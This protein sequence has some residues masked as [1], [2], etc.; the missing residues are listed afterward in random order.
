V[1]LWFIV[2]GHAAAYTTGTTAV[3]EHA[4]VASAGPGTAVGRLAFGDE[5]GLPRAWYAAGPLK[6]YLLTDADLARLAD[7]EPAALE[8]LHWAIA[9]GLAARLRDLSARY[10]A[11]A[12]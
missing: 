5:G 4:Q 12:G 11:L 7:D 3:G 8:A 9:R 6:C 2:S 10:Q 1:P